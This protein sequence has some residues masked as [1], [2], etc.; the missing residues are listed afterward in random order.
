[1]WETRGKKGWQE[2]LYN[3]DLFFKVQENGYS[4]CWSWLLFLHSWHHSYCTWQMW[5]REVKPCFRTR[6]V[7]FIILQKLPCIYIYI[8]ASKIVLKLPCLLK[9]AEWFRKWLQWLPWIESEATSRRWLALLF[10]VPKWNYW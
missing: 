7:Y 2:F 10:F 8:S 4:N 3:L 1:M 5:R 9:S 6:Y